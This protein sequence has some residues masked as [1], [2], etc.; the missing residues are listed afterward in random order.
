MEKFRVES[1]DQLHH[2]WCVDVLDDEPLVLF[3]A[4]MVVD[5]G[6]GTLLRE[7]L[8]RRYD[9]LGL[10]EGSKFGGIGEGDGRLTTTAAIAIHPGVTVFNSQV[11]AL[12]L[13]P[14]L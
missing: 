9:E 1:C 14:D 12:P 8:V 7:E 3:E 11:Q 2:P 4:I 13:G 10:N 6:D 5:L